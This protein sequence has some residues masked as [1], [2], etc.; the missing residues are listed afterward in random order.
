MNFARFQLYTF[1]GS[2]PFCFALAY[3]GLKLGQAWDSSPALRRVIHALDA[4]V[5]VA[6][7][8]ALIWGGLRIWKRLRR[9]LSGA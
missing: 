6:I 5:I 1:L 4:V 8:V 3:V 2:W 9:G 7:L